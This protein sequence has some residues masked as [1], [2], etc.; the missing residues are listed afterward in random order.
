M[1]NFFKN[2]QKKKAS[3]GIKP[4]E[5]LNT[6]FHFKPSPLLQALAPI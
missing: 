3:P 1:V 6:D 4:I 5:M 2:K